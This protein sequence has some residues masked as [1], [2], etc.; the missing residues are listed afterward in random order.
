MMGEVKTAL[1][2]LHVENEVH[3]DSLTA[4]SCFCFPVKFLLGSIQKGHIK[5]HFHNTA[6]T[7]W[8]AI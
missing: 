3:I 7:E 2:I 1:L 5:E 8:E 4:Y 6:V